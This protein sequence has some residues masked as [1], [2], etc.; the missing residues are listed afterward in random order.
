M[1]EIVKDGYILNIED[2]QP[3]TGGGI[4]QL[5]ARHAGEETVG[6]PYINRGGRLTHIGA[7]E[8]VTPQQGDRIGFTAPFETA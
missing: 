3:I 6:V 2:D 7:N 5:M 4:Q 8:Q 1:A